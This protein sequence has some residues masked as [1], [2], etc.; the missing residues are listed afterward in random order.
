M[1]GLAGFF[2]LCF[3]LVNAQVR[4]S[5]DPFSTEYKAFIKVADKHLEKKEYK[6][7]AE[8]YEKGFAANKGNSPAATD[9][10]KLAGCRAQLGSKDSAFAYLKSFENNRYA[11]VG[12]L[13]LNT[14]LYPLH[15]DLRWEQIVGVVKENRLMFIP[16]IHLRLVETLD[17]IFVDDQQYRRKE[18]ETKTKYGENSEEL[19]TLIRKISYYD[20]INL[21]K[22]SQILDLYG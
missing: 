22:V 15:D 10:I 3:S 19:K 21:T 12:E 13:T 18:A 20:S 4:F 17:T 16:Q 1:K 8:N 14:D 9:L 11:K 5:A 7:A 6:L 2:I